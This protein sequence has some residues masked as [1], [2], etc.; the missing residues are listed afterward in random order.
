VRRFTTMKTHYTNSHPAEATSKI[1]LSD[2]Q[3][4]I[5]AAKKVLANFDSRGTE[6]D[7][8]SDTAFDK[9]ASSAK[10]MG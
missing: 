10:P 8:A 5:A 1:Y 2:T 7:S 4:L 6:I 9:F 3:L